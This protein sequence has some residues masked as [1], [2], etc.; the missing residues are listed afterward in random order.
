MKVH[1]RCESLVAARETP[2]AYLLHQRLLQSWRL[3]SGLHG[4]LWLRL[5]VIAQTGLANWYAPVSHRYY[6]SDQER[7]AQR[8]Y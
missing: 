2:L 7:R 5:K 6:V 3:Q 4:L 1:W 8:F